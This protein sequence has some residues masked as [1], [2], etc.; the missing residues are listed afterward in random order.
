MSFRRHL[1]SEEHRKGFLSN[2]QRVP[3]EQTDDLGP[4]FSEIN[5][6]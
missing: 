5:N 3:V 4:S 2:L 6:T 1:Q